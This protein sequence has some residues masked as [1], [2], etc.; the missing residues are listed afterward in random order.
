[1]AIDH[2]IELDHAK[3]PHGNITQTTAPRTHTQKHGC[4]SLSVLTSP[5]C[6]DVLEMQGTSCDTYQTCSSRVQNP[7]IEQSSQ[8][9]SSRVTC[10]CKDPLQVQ[11]DLWW[12]NQ[13]MWMCRSTTTICKL[14]NKSGSAKD[15]RKKFTDKMAGKY[16]MFWRSKSSKRWPMGGVV[17]GKWERQVHVQWIL[18]LAR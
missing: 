14:S 5:T 9:R 2:L 7:K 11:D 3:M 16:R 17:H 18:L 6:I 10:L 8:V 4:V 15:H 13:S 12:T 1:M